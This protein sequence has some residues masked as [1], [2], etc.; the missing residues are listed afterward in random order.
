SNYTISYVAGSVSVTAAPQTISFGPLTNQTWG[1]GTFTVSAT[2]TSGLAVQFASQTP[3]TCT[4]VGT[5]AVFTL[6]STGTCTITASQPGSLNYQAATPVTQS[7]TIFKAASSV[8]FVEDF[9]PTKLNNPLHLAVTVTAVNP[10]AGT[11]SGQVQLYVDGTASGAPVTLGSGLATITTS[12]IPLGTHSLTVGYLGS[13]L[14]LAGTSPAQTHRVVSRLTTTTAV[15]ASPTSTVYYQNVIFTATIT[16]QNAS[17]GVTPSGTVQFTRDGVN[18]G[19]P[20]PVDVNGQARFSTVNSAVGQH[21]IAAIYSGD[22]NYSASTSQGLQFTVARAAT[23][24]ILS[25][26][27]PVS[28]AGAI[29]YRATVAA[30]APGGGVPTGNVRFYRGGTLIGTAALVAGVATLTY[31]NTTLATGTY[32]MSARYGGSTSYRTSVSPG[33]AQRVTL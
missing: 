15:V 27:T 20:V 22:T 7:L 31:T 6:V 3:A 9:D 4:N 33:V 10:A 12:A 29:V 30:V 11:P 17:L 16:R 1:V 24:T 8:V 14:F 13:T 18:L 23:T 26:A 28:R 2:A 32:T 19:A 25:L 5:G 21:T